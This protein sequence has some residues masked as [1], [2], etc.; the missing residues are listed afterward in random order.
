MKNF[1]FKRIKEELKSILLSCLL[2]F[3]CFVFIS[4][5]NVYAEDVENKSDDTG[6]Y[7]LDDTVVTATKTGETKLQE[8]P[9]SITAFDA[10]LL[11]DRNTVDLQDLAKYSPNT[12]ISGGQYPQVYIRGVGIDWSIVGNESG[13]GLYLNDVYLERGLGAGDSFVDIERVEILRG[14]QGTLW[15]RNS[16]GGAINIITKGA[17][18]EFE[19]DLRSEIGSFGKIRFDASVSGPIVKDKFKARLT[20]ADSKTDGYIDNVILGDELRGYEFTAVRGVLDYTPSDA[21]TIELRPS[22][23]TSEHSGQAVKTTE[24]S[25][26]PGYVPPADPYDME[27]NFDPKGTVDSYG[28]STH[29]KIDLPNKLQLKS[30]SA[31]TNR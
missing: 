15:G 31:F 20:V 17:S 11:E 19:A 18:D 25:L 22:Y 12:N 13:V 27:A 29:V 10:E 3:T 8:T 26:V 30:I 28:I 16:T 1:N 14:P 5:S 7:T 23:L 21:I 9:I 24:I 4:A 2:I 6:D